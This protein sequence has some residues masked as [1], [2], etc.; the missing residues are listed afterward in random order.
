MPKEMIR[1]PNDL[2]GR[3]GE[4]ILVCVKG[5]VWQ[6]HIIFRDIKHICI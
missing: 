2:M 6:D 4:K 1:M 3:I 5:C